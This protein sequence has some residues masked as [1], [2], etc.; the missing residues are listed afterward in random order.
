MNK[1]EKLQLSNQV[2]GWLSGEIAQ[3]N[4]II[5]RLKETKHIEGYCVGQYSFDNLDYLENKL[6]ELECRSVFESRN[7]K[8]I[9][10]E[11]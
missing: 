3:V 2:V 5:K 1:R 7:I 10:Y 6:K 9:R 4:H 11:D 8:K